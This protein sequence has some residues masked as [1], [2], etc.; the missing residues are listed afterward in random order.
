MKSEC[1]F[2]PKISSIIGKGE[3][4]GKTLV[5]KNSPIKSKNNGWIKKWKIT[6]SRAIPGWWRL[7]HSQEHE[8]QIHWITE[9]GQTWNKLHS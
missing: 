2:L 8:S 3:Y 6:P 4:E 1:I 7:L 9:Q 5:S